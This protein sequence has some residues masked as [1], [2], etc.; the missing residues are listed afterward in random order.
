MREKATW[1]HPRSRHW[2]M[3]DIVL[4]RS[5]YQ[6]DVLVTKT[7]PGAD[8]WTNH[9]LVVSK[10]RIRLQ[11]R[12]RSQAQRLAALPVAAAAVAAA[13]DEN[14]SVEKRWC[15]LRDTVQSTALAVL[16]HARRQHRKLFDDNDAAII[17][18]LAEKNLL[19]KACVNRP[20]DDNKT[21]FYRSRSLVQQ[22][23]SEMRDA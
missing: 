16:G 8:G 23:L 10:M 5:R 17:N 18:L 22:W 19:H 11:P 7:I 14:A 1:M 15:Q 13:V 2:N 3:L 20:N 9:R 12:R 6:Q 4:V 21:A